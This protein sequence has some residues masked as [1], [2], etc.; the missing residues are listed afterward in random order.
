MNKKPVGIYKYKSCNLFSLTNALDLISEKYF[1]SE[2]FSKLTHLKKIILPGIGNMMSFNKSNSKEITSKT[3][4]L[5]I[6][7]LVE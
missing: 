4:I 1:I 7:K 6:S 5:P 3:V 2:D